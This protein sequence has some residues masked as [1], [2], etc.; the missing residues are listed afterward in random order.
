MISK[1]TLLILVLNS[2]IDNLVSGK[3]IDSENYSVKK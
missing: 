1:S 3:G 2:I